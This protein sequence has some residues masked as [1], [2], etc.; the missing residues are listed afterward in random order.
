M[1][2][3]DQPMPFQVRKGQLISMPYSFELNDIPVMQL[4][5][6][7]RTRYAALVKP[8]STSSTRRAR[9]AAWCCAMPIHPYIIG[10]PHRI[11][12]LDEGWRIRDRTRGV[13]LATGREIADWYSAHHYEAVAAWLAAGRRRRR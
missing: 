8:P 2:H 11:A 10:Q 3:D 4:R 13:W 9:R 7:P 12:A 1:V 6:T 5:G